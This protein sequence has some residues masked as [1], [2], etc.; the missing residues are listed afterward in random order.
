[1]LIFASSANTY[2]SHNLLYAFGKSFIKFEKKSGPKTLSYGVP[3]V[4][5]S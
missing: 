4:T 3:L 5:L 1:M 2:M